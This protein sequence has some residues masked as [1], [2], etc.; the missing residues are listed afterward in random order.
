MEDVT[1]ELGEEMAWSKFDEEEREVLK[2]FLEHGHAIRRERAR[3]ATAKEEPNFIPLV[4]AWGG[5]SLIYR[6][7]LQD[8]PAYR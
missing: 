7:R 3:A 6:K 5:V 2:E 4:R 1:A 8:S